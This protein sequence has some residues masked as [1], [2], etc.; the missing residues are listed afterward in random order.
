MRRCTMGA[1]LLLA[2]AAGAISAQAKGFLPRYRFHPLTPALEGRLDPV[3][4]GNAAAVVRYGTWGQATGVLV[5]GVPGRDATGLL[6]TNHH[7]YEGGPHAEMAFADGQRGRLLRLVAA[8]KT[9]DYALVEIELPA[10]L[11]ARPVT[12]GG[13]EATRGEEV[14]AIS[15]S[16]NPFNRR[17]RMERM[18]SIHPANRAA[19]QQALA[20]EAM[21]TIQRGREA[22]RGALRE[23]PV[24]GAA[25]TVRSSVFALPNAPG[26]SGSPVFSLD[27]E[28]VALHWAG[29][30]GRGRWYASGVPAS[31]IL[32]DL[33]RKAQSGALAAD[34]TAR[35]QSVVDAARAR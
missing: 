17:G 27:H 7:V 3:T 4:R 31:L 6:L 30:R 29:A 11:A 19:V 34:V 20:D 18:V 24:P 5:A 12:I 21:R 32:A 1:C 25:H 35:V 23:V 9:L 2:L 22:G 13:R 16:A 15:A 10:T 28:M 26:A 8:E 33:E 14:Y